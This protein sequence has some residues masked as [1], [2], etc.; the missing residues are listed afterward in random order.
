MSYIF[1][2]LGA[3][4]LL[5]IG[6][7]SMQVMLV[8]RMRRLEGKAAPELA[9]KYEKWV[10]S[11]KTALFYFYSPACGACRTMTPVVKKLGQSNDGVFAVDITQDMDTARKFGVMATPTTIVVG[12]GFVRRV[13]VGPQPPELLESTISA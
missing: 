2:G 3:L 4:V 8:R 13:L 1:Y 10:K 6:F 5:F 7:I 11:G 12:D 9:G